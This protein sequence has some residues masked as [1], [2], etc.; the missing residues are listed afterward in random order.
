MDGVT[1]K[2]LYVVRHAEAED[3]GPGGDLARRLTPRGRR[4]AAALFRQLAKACS[5]PARVVA[6]AAVRARETAE[7]L[8]RA[9]GGVER[10]VDARLNPGAPWAAWRAAAL[11][12]LEGVDAAAIVG[13]EPEG[14]AAV[15]RLIGGRAR[16]EM[17]KGAVAI[18][19]VDR[20]LRGGKLTVLVAPR[21]AR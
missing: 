3:P 18:L 8:D 4:R 16:V 21:W 2:I 1:S 12:A 6:S 13:H 11:A 15:G 5:A 9:W 7:L 10:G 20:R 19:E 14:S 17:K